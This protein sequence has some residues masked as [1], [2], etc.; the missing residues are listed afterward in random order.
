MIICLAF[1]QVFPGVVERIAR[2]PAEIRRRFVL[3]PAHIACD[4]SSGSGNSTAYVM[5]TIR[6]TSATRATHRNRTL[7]SIPPSL[8]LSLSLFFLSFRGRPRARLV[9]VSLLAGLTRSICHNL[10]IVFATQ[11]AFMGQ[12]EASRRTSSREMLLARDSPAR[13]YHFPPI[14]SAHKHRP[15]F[16]EH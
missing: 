2:Y 12:P 8:S 16:Q 14:I 6:A 10:A 13:L 5:L 11:I 4:N 3:P 7:I 9:R 15:C 1:D